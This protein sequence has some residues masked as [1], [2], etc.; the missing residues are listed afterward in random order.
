MR[1]KK[2]VVKQRPDHIISRR[3]I[4]RDALTVMYRLKRFGYEGFLVGGGVRDLLLKRKPKD[5]DVCTDAHPRKIKRIFRNCF[6]IGRRF[7]LAHIKF[8]EKIIETST[9][10]REPSRAG[11]NM[12]GD[13]SARS[14]RDNTFGTAE[15]DARRRDFTINALFYDIRDFSIIDHVGGLEDLDRR[16]VRSIGNSNERFVEDPVRMM[17]AVR[18]A[19]RL[20]FDIEKSTLKAIR[21][22]RGELAEAAPPRLLEEVSRLFGYGSGLSAFRLMNDTG[23]LEVLFPELHAHLERNGRSDALFWRHLAALDDLPRRGEDPP[24]L[25]LIFSVLSHAPFLELVADPGTGVDGKPIRHDVAREVLGPVAQ[26][27]KMPKNVFFSVVHALEGQR[28]FEFT[29]ERFSRKRFVSHCAFPDTLALR[30]V[31]LKAT[32]RSLDSLASWRELYRKHLDDIATG[33]V[34]RPTPPPKR[35]RRRRRRRPEA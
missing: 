13:G 7:R 10:R 26:R 19:S 1:K 15:E 20:A 21:R 35:R 24:P 27:F 12:A 16:L 9:F 18:F 8:G 11:R 5:F 6:L 30:E 32:G 14:R 31:H 25:A 17:R 22:N 28:R 29:D 33:R 3:D 2:P 4:D 34:P 23:L